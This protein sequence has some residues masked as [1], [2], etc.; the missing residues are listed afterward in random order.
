MKL[1]GVQAAAV[2]AMWMQARAANGKAAKASAKWNEMNDA[3]TEFFEGSGITDPV[4]IAR[5]KGNNLELQEHFG[6]Y[7]FWAGE[8]QRLALAIQV[9]YQATQMIQGGG[10]WEKPQAEPRT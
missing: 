9:E 5:R 7:Q 10:P 1:Q 4:D 8:A 2:Q 3:L 6:M